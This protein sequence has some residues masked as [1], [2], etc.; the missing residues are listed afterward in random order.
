VSPSRLVILD[1]GSAEITVP[2]AGKVISLGRVGPGK[3]LGLRPILCGEVSEINV[4]CL[5]DC[6]VTLLS[7]ETFL[8]VL[9]R[10]PHMY[11]SV[12]K[13]LSADLKTVQ[14]FLR[15]KRGR[16]NPAARARFN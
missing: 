5:E 4:S 14:S 1:S 11:F 7:R 8:E 15:K 2:A 10:N 3:V 6:E 9:R 13:V 16:A 12:V